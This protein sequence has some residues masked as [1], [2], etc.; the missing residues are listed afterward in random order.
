MCVRE[1]SF[2][3]RFPG[4]FKGH[5]LLIFPWISMIPLG[6]DVS[7]KLIR[8][9]LWTL[10]WFPDS[11]PGY[12][13]LRH[14][15]PHTNVGNGEALND[16][17][18]Y[19][20]MHDQWIAWKLFENPMQPKIK[21]RI[22]YISITHSAHPCHPLAISNPKKSHYGLKVTYKKA[23]QFLKVLLLCGM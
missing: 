19:V 21:T 10:S 12:I 13:P 3:I 20:V 16:T 8:N 9:Y 18:L 5:I 6:L 1:F 2:P 11:Q 22:I 14:P 17:P 15:S 4:I 7:K 23:V